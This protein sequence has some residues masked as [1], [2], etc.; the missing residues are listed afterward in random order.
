MATRSRLLVRRPEWWRASAATL[1]LFVL[2]ALDAAWAQQGSTAVIERMNANPIPIVTGRPPLAYFTFAYDLAAVLNNGDELRVLP[3]VS[4]GAFQNV[5]DVR[6][7]PGVD[8]GFAQTNILGYYR[9]T[10]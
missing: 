10:G 2:P 1:A 5:R 4:Q 8:L 6:Y 9:R 3:V 7:L